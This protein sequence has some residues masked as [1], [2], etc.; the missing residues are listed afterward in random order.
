MREEV[1]DFLREYG[2]SKEEIFG[3]HDNNSKIFYVNK[4]MV[5][6]N[7]N[8]M[9]SLGL[10]K[11]EIIELVRR[12]I[13]MVTVTKKKI[14]YMTNLYNNILNFNNNEIKEI[15]LKFPKMYII[16][17]LNVEKLIELY[18]SKDYSLKDI[19]NLIKIN[20]EILGIQ[21]D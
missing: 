10:S 4:K 9:E 12:N 17:P 16:N 7:F 15:L 8:F 19:K 18:K 1:F 11:E 6:Y 14:E 20:P 2:F 3:Y 13:F 5:V 21:L